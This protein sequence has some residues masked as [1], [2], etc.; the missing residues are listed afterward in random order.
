[1]SWFRIFIFSGV[2][3]GGVVHGLGFEFLSFGDQWL[4]M[5]SAWS[6]VQI[7]DIF[8]GQWWCSAWSWVRILDFW[9]SIVV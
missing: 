3:N 7:F 8:E 9:G 6:L 4:T 1:M 2:I 5:C